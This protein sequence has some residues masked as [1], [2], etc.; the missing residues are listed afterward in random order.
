MLITAFTNARQ[1]SLSW[2]SSIQSITPH[3]TAILILSSHLRLS[4]P[5]GLF[6]SGHWL[7]TFPKIVK[8]LNGPYQWFK[9]PGGGGGRKNLK[10]NKKKV[11][12]FDY[13]SHDRHGWIPIFTRVR[14]S[15]ISWH[16]HPTT[17]HNEIKSRIQQS[18]VIHNG[19]RLLCEAT[20]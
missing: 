4:P 14:R 17:E 5:S 19:R 16:D 10:T 15:C 7:R 18:I 3:P 13:P 1:L 9:P 11:R 2:A 20:G 8:F 6:P 12:E